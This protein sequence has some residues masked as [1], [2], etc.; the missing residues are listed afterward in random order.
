MSSV[1]HNKALYK[2]VVAHYILAA[3]F[4]LVLA[5]MLLFSAD[6][7]FG[8]YFQPKLLALTHTAGLGWGTLII[9]GALYR[10]LPVILETDLHSTKLCWLSLAFFV[11]GTATLIYSFWV[12]HP[13]IYMQMAGVSILIGIVVF[14]INVYF[15]AKQQKQTSINQ[16]FILTSSIWLMFTTIVGLLMIFNFRYPFLPK[17]HLYFLRLHAHLGLIGWFL[18]LIIGVSSKLIPMFLVS[19]YQKTHLIRYSYYLINTA[20]LLFLIN[21]YLFGINAF[22][23]VIYALGIIGIASFWVYLYNCF[24]TRLRKRIDLPMVKSLLSF[25]FLGLAIL[26]LPFIIYYHIKSDTVAIRLSVV[27]GVLI[28][29]GWISNLILGQTFKTLPFIIWMKHY[30]DLTGKVKTPM[31]ANLFSNRILKIQSVSFL[32]FLIAFTTGILSGSLVLIY[33]G[34]ISV[35]ITAISYGVNI[36]VMF[37]H[38]IKTISYDHI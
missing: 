11:P 4:F 10:L 22:T 20:L 8:H 34:A 36:C 12:F 3:I 25:V 31:P 14:A 5:F 37:F 1:K 30:G 21:G 23:Y 18:M 16:E 35:V 6:S 32:A 9:F 33:T 24:A 26:V 2:V 28:F 7:F 27:Y 13:G 17:D 29:M 19:K 15:T 38:K